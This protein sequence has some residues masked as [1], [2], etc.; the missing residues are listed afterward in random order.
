MG[1]DIM[2]TAGRH[3]ETKANLDYNH[4]VPCLQPVSTIMSTNNVWDSAIL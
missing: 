3:A 2:T 4:Q 1:M